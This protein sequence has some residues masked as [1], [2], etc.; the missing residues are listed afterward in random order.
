MTVIRQ[1]KLR[2]IG[3][4][5]SLAN[6]DKCPSNDE[7][8]VFSMRR[9][10]HLLA[11]C[12]QNTQWFSGLK[13]SEAVTT[14]NKNWFYP[15]QYQIPKA[16]NNSISEMIGILNDK[17]WNKLQNP[18]NTNHSHRSTLQTNPQIED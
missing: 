16:E 9:K 15:V 2:I 3:Y 1:L 7:M 18:D 4:T 8:M 17:L 5:Q 6:R 11:L 12:S 13:L 10:I 14:N